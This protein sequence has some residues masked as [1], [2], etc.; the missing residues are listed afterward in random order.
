MA[1]RVNKV[2]HDDKTREKIRTTQLLK[3]LHAYALGEDDPQNGKPVELS[4]GQVK[5]IEVLLRKSLPDLQSIS[6]EMD[7][8]HRHEDALGQLE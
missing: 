8:N 4:T 5:A 7:L 6:G 3:R 1:A 2:K